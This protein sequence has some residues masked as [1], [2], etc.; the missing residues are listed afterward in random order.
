MAYCD[1]CERSFVSQQALQQHEEDSNMHNACTTCGTDFP[2]RSRLV[3]HWLQSPHHDYCKRCDEHFESRDDLTDHL[4]D[5]HCY[6]SVCDRI[7]D[8]E[9][10]LREHRRQSHPDLYCVSCERMFRAENS[11]K[12]HLGSAIHKDKAYDCPGQHCNKSFASPAALMQHWES[13]ACP[14]GVTREIV[15]RGASALDRLITDRMRTIA[16]DYLRT[17]TTNTVRAIAAEPWVAELAWNGSAYE[18]YMCHRTYASSRAL[19]NH[20]QSPAHSD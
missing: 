1:R 3:Q 7:F 19:A 4:E 10:G 5:E 18:C 9:R 6:C 15:K 16:M 14:S 17:S 12:Q 20:V 13:G 8:H 11:L 2:E